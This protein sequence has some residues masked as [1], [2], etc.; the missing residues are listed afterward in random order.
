MPDLHAPRNDRVRFWSAAALIVGLVLVAYWPAL[1]GKPLWDDDAHLTKPELQSVAG[2]GRIW[3]DPRATQQYYPLLHSVFWIEHAVFGDA[4]PG[5]HL[6]NVLLHATDAILLMLILSRLGVPGAPLAGLLFAVHPVCVESVAWISEQKNTLSLAFYLLSALAYLKF[7]ARRGERGATR[8]YVLALVLFVLAL[9]SKTVTATLPAALLVVFWWKRGR[10]GWRRDALPLV[11]WFAL[12]A[13]CGT[14]TAVVERKL[15]GAEGAQFDLTLIER[16]LLAGR[17]VWFYL[18]KLVWPADLAFIYRRWNVG[19]DA[20]AWTVALIAAALVT[21]ALWMARGR[22]RGPL[23]AWLFFVGSLFPAL[24]F[25]NVYPFIFSYVADHFQYLACIGIISGASAG[26]AMA[27]ARA[28]R[29]FQAVGWGLAAV[30][31]ATLVLLSNAQS[32]TYA[33][34]RT[35]YATTLERNPECW[36]ADNNLGLWYKDRGNAAKAFAL[37]AEALRLRPRYAQAHNNIGVCYEDRGDMDDAI[38]HFQE[39]IRLTKAYAAAHNNLG[40]ALGSVPG[41]LNEAIAQFEEALREEPNFAEAHNNLG[42]ALMKAPDRM[43]E[44]MKQF[45]D[46]LRLKPDYAEAHAALADA[47]ATFP[48]RLDEAVAEYKEALRLRPDFAEAHNNLGLVLGAQGRTMEAIAQFNEALRAAPGFAEIHL[49]IAVALLNLPGA[50]NEVIEQV[51]AYLRVR[52]E[53]ETT[54]QILAQIQPSQP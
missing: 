51:R 11:P 26:A 43:N 22:S 4:T 36:M 7:D 10:L 53:N 15:I 2:L 14:V 35:L 16:C 1:P 28:P 49:N 25:F 47:L 45:R 42:S 29:R 54:R 32:A 8:S 48:D 33:D 30:V 19:A 12:A 3:T 46:A 21:A 5:Y 44:A 24:G 6:V 50:R 52:P 31:V 34:S 9:L 17:V 20:G 23:A 40:T 27:M 39:A 38:A 18:G 41:R 13:A 37:Y